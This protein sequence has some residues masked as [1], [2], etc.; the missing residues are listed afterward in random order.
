MKKPEKSAG[1][2]DSPSVPHDAVRAVDVNRGAVEANHPAVD[3]N[4]CA[5]GANQGAADHRVV[6]IRNHP[7]SSETQA[8]V[9]VAL[10]GDLIFESKIAATARAGGVAV[11]S[12]RTLDALVAQASAAGAVLVL[13]DLNVAGIGATKTGVSGAI[14][15]IHGECPATRIVAFASHVDAGLLE[16]ARAAGADEVMPRSRFDASLAQIL[17]TCPAARKS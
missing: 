11:Q 14:A 8:P 3:A 7:M 10:V 4:H 2:V 15:R 17:S 1:L 6:T 5:V 12:V 16:Q 13:M 9:A